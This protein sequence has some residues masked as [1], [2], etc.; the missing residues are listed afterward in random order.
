MLPSFDNEGLLPPGIH[1][2][3]WEDVRDQLGWNARRQELLLGLRNGLIALN[4]AWCAVVFLDGSF[5]TS[6]DHPGD[7]DACYDVTGMDASRLDRVFFQFGN[8]RAAQKLRFGGEFFPSHLG[9]DGVRPFFEFFQIDK[10]SGR[11][12]G[13]IAIK[14]ASAL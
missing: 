13:I 14:P 11:Q 9:A 1:P 8:G 10:Q 4:A 3:S 12:K 6:K 5:A 2:G 7:Y